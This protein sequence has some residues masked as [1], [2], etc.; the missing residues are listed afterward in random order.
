LY[1]LAHSINLILST[2]R[3]G[4][5]LLLYVNLV[6][7]ITLPFVTIGLETSRLTVSSPSQQITLYP[8]PNP[9]WLNFDRFTRVPFR[10]SE[11]IPLVLSVL[12]GGLVGY[13]E[14]GVGVFEP[15]KHLK[16]LLSI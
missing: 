15:D 1:L 10:G 3:F 11:K 13:E 12:S 5:D 14:G 6:V 9:S 4:I 7:N 2:H 8:S 16:E